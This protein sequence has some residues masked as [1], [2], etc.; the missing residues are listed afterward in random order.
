VLVHVGILGLLPARRDCSEDA[1]RAPLA[2]VVRDVNDDLPPISC[3]ASACAL[4]R[5]TS[6]DAQS[7]A[8][9]SRDLFSTAAE[10]RH[11]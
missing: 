10:S 4:M 6:R 8:P 7:D 2:R 9:C 11:R 3:R 1:S 5:P